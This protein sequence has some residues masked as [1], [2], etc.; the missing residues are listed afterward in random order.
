MEAI[1]FIFDIAKQVYGP[2]AMKITLVDETR[3]HHKAHG[4]MNITIADSIYNF[5]MVWS[6]SCSAVD[7]LKIPD[8]SPEFQVM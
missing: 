5:L 2:N 8:V 3:S 7:V 6:F 4:P 1:R